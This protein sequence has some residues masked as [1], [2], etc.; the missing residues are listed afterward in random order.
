MHLTLEY[1]RER[2]FYHTRTHTYTH[3][4]AHF[5]ML[6]K[7]TMPTQTLPFLPLS[8]LVGSYFSPPVGIR[9]HGIRR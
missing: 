4:H 9:N 1:P 5:F 2:V 3:T 8:H 7:R 6:K